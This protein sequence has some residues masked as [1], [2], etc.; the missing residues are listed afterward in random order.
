MSSGNTRCSGTCQTWIRE[1]CK[2]YGHTR[3]SF[4]FCSDYLKPCN[5]CKNVPSSPSSEQGMKTGSTTILST[6]LHQVGKNFIEVI[7]EVEPGSVV[8]G[9]VPHRTEDPN[10]LLQNIRFKTTIRGWSHRDHQHS[11]TSLLSL[12]DE[13]LVRR[14]SENQDLVLLPV[15]WWT[16]AN[17]LTPNES[18]WWYKVS[19]PI[20]FRECKAC[21]RRI[22][23]DVQT[24]H[25][26]LETGVC[27]KCP[28]RKPPH[29]HSTRKK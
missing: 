14:M 28:I 23:E 21:A 7:S 11:V 29:E 10:Q 22:G 20:R 15:N 9:E 16:F 1:T 3:C 25:E 27:P 13:P 19:G 17:T 5:T 6:N 18:G 26:T 8:E 24:G 12:Q 4:S 2:E